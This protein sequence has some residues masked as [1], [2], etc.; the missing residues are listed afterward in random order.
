MQ[1]F[2]RD[3]AAH[4][5]P[6]NWLEPVDGTWGNY[7]IFPILKSTSDIAYTPGKKGGRCCTVLQCG[8]GF[9]L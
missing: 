2:L 9:D 6:G 5:G 7:P 4:A 8:N 3:S 1:Y